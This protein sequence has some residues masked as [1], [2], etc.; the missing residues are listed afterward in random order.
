M[1]RIFRILISSFFLPAILLILIACNSAIDSCEHSFVE[2]G[3]KE[4]CTQDG[5]LYLECAKCGHLAEERLE[6]IGHDEVIINAV[7]ATCTTN[8]STEGKACNRCGE[9]IIVPEEIIAGHQIEI[10]PAK[11]ETCTENGLTEG[12]FCPVCNT[13]IEPQ[14]SILAGHKF[15]IISAIEPTCTE[16]GRTE[17][18][19]CVRCGLVSKESHNIP[20]G[21][22]IEY[23]G[24]LAET[25]MT[26]GHTAGYFCTE[27]NL[28]LSGIEVIPAAHK[29]VIIPGKEGY[30]ASCTSTGM[31]PETVCIVC[32]A[33][34]STQKEIPMAEHSFKTVAGYAATCSSEGLTDGSCC[35]VCGYPEEEQ[36]I[37][38]M[39]NHI[40]SV[41]SGYDA[42]CTTA[43]LTDG[44]ECQLC[45]YTLKAQCLISPKGH[46]L[47]KDGVCTACSISVTAELIYEP[48]GNG[49]YIVAGLTEGAVPTTII[50]PE[51][52]NDTSVVGIKDRAFDSTVSIEKVI[53]PKTIE[54]I[55]EDAFYN[56]IYLKVIELA[57]ISQIKDLGDEWYKNLSAELKIIASLYNGKNPYEVCVAAMNAIGDS[58]TI[59][60][61]FNTYISRE[62]EMSIML[63]R[64]THSQI[65]GQDFLEWTEETDFLSS[66]VSSQLSL[67]YIDGYLYYQDNRHGLCKT[68]ISYEDLL[69]FLGTEAIKGTPIRMKPEDFRSSVFY[70]D[71]NG[72]MHI[73]LDLSAH[74]FKEIALAMMADADLDGALLEDCKFEY[75]LD[76]NGNLLS[77]GFS[78]IKNGEFK[79]EG[80]CEITNIDS[81][82][83]DAGHPILH[84]AILI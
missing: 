2:I 47:D 72:E 7:S 61:T 73:S 62:G 4:Y 8:G 67:G 15:E 19:A 38:P 54:F 20:A 41:V 14:Q 5:I 77:Y 68:A 45:G 70:L 48:F 84:G 3:R 56:C 33:T 18:E 49:Q 55:G 11:P 46:S 60:S 29:S 58:Y 57:D 37:I 83:V 23:L 25:C 50:I 1:R 75:I 30:A 13:V 79:I 36:Q 78:A 26:D 22:T 74:R 63:S 17:G 21:H 24:A 42:G 59:D 52:H 6:P 80:M 65:N 76:G 82:A 27:C 51:T 9:Q 12:K 39:L 31:S 44:E 69:D 66:S 34:T 40:S 16:D 35:A 81:T 32:H 28:V 53:V 10:I 64:L 71:L 43:G